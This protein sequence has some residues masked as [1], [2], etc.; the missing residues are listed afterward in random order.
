M[1]KQ[2]GF[3]VK[4]KT[5]TSAVV[6]GQEINLTRFSRLSAVAQLHFHALP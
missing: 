6:N 4:Q 2:P 3:T 5:T 1:S